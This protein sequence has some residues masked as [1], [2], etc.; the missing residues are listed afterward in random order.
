MKQRLTT[1]IGS[2]LPA[3]SCRWWSVCRAMPH[4]RCGQML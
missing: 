3:Q 4:G 2:P 1:R